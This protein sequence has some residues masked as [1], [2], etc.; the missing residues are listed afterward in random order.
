MVNAIAV[1]VSAGVNRTRCL[2]AAA[3]VLAL[4]G[5]ALVRDGI[6][7]DRLAILAWVAL[8]LAAAWGWRQF[9]AQER[10]RHSV[11]GRVEGRSVQRW[12]MV[13]VGVALVAGLATQTWFR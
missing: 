8:G 7:A 5:L 12:L 10:L 11:L 13:A 6:V 9:L 2:S 3:G 4:L 1:K